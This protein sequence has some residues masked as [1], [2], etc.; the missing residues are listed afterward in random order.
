MILGGATAVAIGGLA[1]YRHRQRRQALYGELARRRRSV[2]EA[3][4]V[5]IATP[6]DAAAGLRAEFD[7]EGIVRAVGFVAADALAAYRQEAQ[8]ARDAVVRSYLPRHKKGGTLSYERVHLDAPA[9]LA[10][11]HSNA[12]RQW[13]STL[14]GQSVYPAADHDQSACSVL[15][16]DQA[17]DHIGWHYDY[18][19]Y[20]GR[21]FTVLLSLHNRAAHGGLSSGRLQRRSDGRVTEIATEEG[22]LVAFE[23]ARVLHRATPVG[24]GDAR[25]MLSMTF[26]T[27]P[28]VSPLREWARRLKDTAYY[29]PR[30]LF[31]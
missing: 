1:W 4:R 26:A 30:A 19:F 12:L 15:Y 17:G 10:F 11:Y 29:G 23:G 3:H 9:C 18:N 22:A 25:I 31:G 27:D 16:Y 20:R 13:L 14:V 5:R 8:A 28:R 2:S 6:R 21:H 7:R 24:E